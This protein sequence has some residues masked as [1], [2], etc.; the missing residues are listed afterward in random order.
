MMPE[1]E[2]LVYEILPRDGV[3]ELCGPPGTYKSFLAL[4][5]ALS[6]ATG[7]DWTGREVK[8]GSVVYIAG[9]GASGYKSRVPSWKR[10]KGVTEEVPFYLVPEAVQFVDTRETDAL[11]VSMR[12]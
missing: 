3:G 7:T 11:I 12:E 4:D 8:Q 2:W 10:A 5:L 1:P 9:E 6:V